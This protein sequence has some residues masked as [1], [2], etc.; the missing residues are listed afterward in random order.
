MSGDG[1]TANM[2]GMTKKEL[3]DIM[4]QMKVLIYV[5]ACNNPY[6]IFVV[7]DSNQFQLSFFLFVTY[8][9]FLHILDKI[10]I[11]YYVFLC[12]R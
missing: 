12:S 1:L 11:I 10:V 5:Y 9:I 7:E 6:T 4:S 3:Y 8:I 2:A